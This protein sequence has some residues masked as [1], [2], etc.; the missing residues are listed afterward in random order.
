[1]KDYLRFFVKDTGI[2][3]N[4]KYHKLIFGRFRQVGS[5]YSASRGGSGLGLAIS[6]AYVQMLGGNISVKSEPGKGSLFIFT[7]PFKKEDFNPI[8]TL[9]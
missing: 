1:V 9:N 3:I 7:L 5:D 8:N 6:K 4:K 2:G